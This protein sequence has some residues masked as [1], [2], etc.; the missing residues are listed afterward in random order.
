MCIIPK[1]PKAGLKR[2]FFAF[3]IAFHFFVA[4]NR[5]YFKFGMWV[6]HSKSQPK[7]DKLSLKWAWSL[8]R[9]LFNF[10]K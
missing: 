10:G 3:G 7:D 4:D 6:E 8:S 2:I 1:S 5:R 9:H